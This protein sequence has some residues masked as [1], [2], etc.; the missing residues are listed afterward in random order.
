MS[1]VTMQV[2]ASM[3]V[4]IGSKSRASVWKELE[5]LGLELYIRAILEVKSGT[6]RFR[7]Q[8]GPRRSPYSDPPASLVFRLWWR[9][10]RKRMG[11]HS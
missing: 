4:P 11:G 2:F 10:T 8:E 1:L 7:A 5:E 9:Q 3:V 6:A